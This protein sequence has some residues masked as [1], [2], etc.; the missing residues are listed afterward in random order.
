MGNTLFKS[1][2]TQLVTMSQRSRAWS[3]T[4]NNPEEKDI[5]EFKNL[6][7]SY[8]CFEMEK[9]ENE[10]PHIQGFIYNKEPI[11]FNTL[12]N[13][14][15][16][17]HIEK[18]TKPPL[19]NIRYC[20]KEDNGTFWEKGVR[21]L[22]VAKDDKKKNDLESLLEKKEITKKDVDDLL[23]YRYIRGIKKFRKMLEEIKEDR[24]CKPEII[25]IYGNSGS[26]KTY[27]AWKIA[28]ENYGTENISD[29]SFANS[30]GNATNVHADCLVYDEFRPA[31]LDAA[32]FLKLTD[33]YGMTLNIK[34]S[35]VYIRPKCV[36]IT[37]IK[38]PDEIYKEEMNEQFKR[39]ITQ[40]INMNENPWKEK[41][42]EEIHFNPFE[43][44]QEVETEENINVNIDKA[45]N[46]YLY[47]DTL[48]F[49][50]QSTARK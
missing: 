1:N 29:I 39:R 5:E 38:H 2:F 49:I 45:I 32:T 13:K 44:I 27:K 31:Q 19:A 12:K 14:L 22:S 36:I 35:M 37:S 11:R 18:C 6:P 34:H 46:K 33:G 26:G 7:Y 15:E 21:P 4:I 17:A 8:L 47:Q 20:Q 30:F 50:P 40:F 41:E 28:A 16:K 25:Y 9:G 42:V 3:I 24:L 43:K 23:A 48:D 10:T